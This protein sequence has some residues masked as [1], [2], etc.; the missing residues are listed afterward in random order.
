[1]KFDRDEMELLTRKYK[2]IIFFPKAAAE[3]IVQIPKTILNDEGILILYEEAVD[4][5]GLPG[6]LAEFSDGCV[7]TVR[8]LSQEEAQEL[9][10]LYFTYEFT[11]NFIMAMENPMYASVFNYVKNGVLTAEEAWQALIMQ[12]I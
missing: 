6:M 9:T 2:K 11:D 3:L 5:G 8:R 7:C 4:D 10:E 1:M 12:E